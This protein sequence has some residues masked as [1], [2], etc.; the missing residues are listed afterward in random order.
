MRSAV[1]EQAPGTESGQDPDEADRRGRNR[2]L[3]G[4]LL[5][6]VAVVGL[7]VLSSLPAPYVV[8]SP[9]PTYDVL[10][11]TTV[12]GQQVPLI[13]IPSEQ[14]YATSGSLR[15]L[16]V[17][18]S[19]P[20]Q[21]PTWL[22]VVQALLDHKDAVVPE[23]DVY[24]P[25]ITEQENDQDS[26]IEMQD[27]QNQAVAAALTALGHPLTP[28]VS[29]ADFEDGSPADGILAK[30]DVLVSFD[31]TAVTDSDQ[32]RD[33]V[34]TNGTT[35]PAS[36]VIER[37]A[38]Q[39]SVEVTPALDSDGKTAVLGIYI[40]DAYDFPFDVKIQL[41]NVGGPS[42]GMM[43]ALGIYDKL[44]DGSLTG[45][46]DVAGTGTIDAAGDVGAIGG[47]R[48]KMWGAKEAGAAYFLA[49]KADCDEVVGHIP[50]GLRV[51]PVS[52]LQDA[53]KALAAISSG[54]GVDALPVCD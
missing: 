29:V 17:Y 34:Q 10:G 46:E 14:T 2:W 51:T 47:I 40:E 27:S 7:G 23:A 41:E 42:A 9:G 38:K 52:T 3:L 21:L 20:D 4:L 1:R 43:M 36:I 26:S 22:Q 53:I 16:T 25:G 33:L 35:K 49:P 28:R 11:D 13:S 24:P 39:R 50:A 12:D 45:G 6:V 32:L 37:D 31:G 48:Q 15:M 8:E 30:G 54:D 44:T 18:V 5:I 19:G